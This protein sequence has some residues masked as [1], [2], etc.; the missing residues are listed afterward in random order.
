MNFHI[1]QTL[2]FRSVVIFFLFSN[3]A[4]LDGF[5]LA[6]IMGGQNQQSPSVSPGHPRPVPPA[7]DV[8]WY[9]AILCDI[10]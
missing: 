8:M 3:Q 1:G 4:C 2:F 5:L 6:F 9:Y 7:V 10:M